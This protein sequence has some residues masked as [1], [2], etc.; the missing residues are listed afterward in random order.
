MLILALG[1]AMQLHAVDMTKGAHLFGSCQA[2]VRMIRDPTASQAKA[3]LPS[4]TYCFGY[5]AGYVDGLNRLHSEVCL[6]GASVDAFAR[7]YVGYMQRN[8]KLTE[9]NRSLGV[10]LAAKDAYPCSV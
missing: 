5:L 8:P 2:A 3:E 10:L 7:V 4:S 6:K 1:L 9:E